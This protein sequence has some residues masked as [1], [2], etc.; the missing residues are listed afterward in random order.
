MAR[1]KDI[2]EAWRAPRGAAETIP[3]PVTLAQQFFILDL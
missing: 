1:E 3:F 2:P